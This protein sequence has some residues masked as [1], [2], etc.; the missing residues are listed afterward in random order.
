MYAIRSYYVLEQFID[1]IGEIGLRRPL[2]QPLS[3]NGGR[4]VAEQQLH[5]AHEVEIAGAHG[6]GSRINLVGVFQT[7]QQLRRITSYNVCYTKLL[8]V[9][10]LPEPV[11]EHL[12]SFSPRDLLEEPLGKPF[13][14]MRDKLDDF[15]PTQWLD[16]VE[17][18]LDALKQRLADAIDVQVLLAPI[19]EA[20]QLLLDELGNF[21]PGAVLEPLTRITSYNVC[22]TK[23][24][25]MSSSSPAIKESV[26]EVR[27]AGSTDM[28]WP[29]I[30]GSGATRVLSSMASRAD[31]TVPM[32]SITSYNFV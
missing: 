1:G 25:R 29:S 19:M 16:V 14:E 21:R 22:Y 23:L 3:I 2:R 17:Q 31:F 4:A 11:F 28:A 12:R 18:E 27:D 20:R 26:N 9:R 8:R 32:P 5:P 30:S 15:Q 7:G 6:V 13:K 10:D 24:L